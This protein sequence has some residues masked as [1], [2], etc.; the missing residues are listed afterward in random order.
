MRSLFE[1]P[2]VVLINAFGIR[3]AIFLAIFCNFSGYLYLVL[4]PYD[5]VITSLVCSFVMVWVL[6]SFLVCFT[7]ELTHIDTLFAK[8]TEDPGSYHA[9]N[10]QPKILS[11]HYKSVF[12]LMKEISRKREK[13]EEYFSEMKYSSEQ[14]ISSATEVSSNAAS[15][16]AATVSTAAAVTELT[17]SLNEIVD[18]F[19]VV[20]E[21]A[22][23]ASDYAQRGAANI[24]DL[25]NEFEEVQSDVH[26]TQSAVVV[27]GQSIE[28]VLSLTS[29]I[30]KIAEQTNLLALNA[31]I[32]AARAGDL[33][34]GFAVVA[35]EVRN[36]AHESRI[37]ADT[38]NSNISELDK[39]R[40]LVANKMDLVT[41]RAHAC[42]SQARE[43][44]D[45]LE[46]IKAE[47]EHSKSQVIEVSAITTQQSKATEE[48]SESIEKV[49]AGALK[50]ANIA[51]ETSAV[52]EYL[53]T[54]S[55]R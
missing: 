26:E 10:Y 1:A 40:K 25:V 7:S 2:A 29:S 50:N 8:A 15:Q 53:R 27:L 47:S 23:N 33:G 28:T 44:V 46:N 34:R 32:E 35:D 36:L 3:S 9:I 14:M 51:K 55:I 22:H 19:T 11:G 18:K 31:S 13:L 48:I 39:Q 38:I 5:H 37:S 49:A 43:A 24:S 45:M 20:N 30:Q 4:S 21:A 12:D 6:A 17:V 16:S 42:F 52:A 41:Q 54:I